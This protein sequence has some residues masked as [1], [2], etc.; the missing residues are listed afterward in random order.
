MAIVATNSGGGD[1]APMDAG[2]YVSRCVQM[3]Q[4]GTVTETID[5]KEKTMHK[6]RFGFEFPTELKVFKEENG[7]QPFFLSKEYTLSMHEKATLRQHLETWRGKKFS[8]EEAQSFDVTKL[9][10]VPCTINVIHKT[11]K[12]NGKTYAEIGSISPLMKGTL[13][14]DQINPTQVLSY[15]NFDVALFESLPEFLRKKIESSKEYKE[16]G[17]GK[18][19]SIPDKEENDDLDKLPF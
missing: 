8:E 18:P 9:I 17:S 1:Y 12:S 11:G 5:G 19:S 14:P 2:M 6:V 3:I 13:C 16:L 7:E 4:I 15:D 10:G